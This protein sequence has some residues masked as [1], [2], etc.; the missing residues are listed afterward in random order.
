MI[1]SITFAKSPD[2]IPLANIRSFQLVRYTQQAGVVL[3]GC[4]KDALMY[5]FSLAGQNYVSFISAS[6]LVSVQPVTEYDL[7][8]VYVRTIEPGEV[9]TIRF[10]E[11]S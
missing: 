5:R 6:E 9:I 1:E 3:T 11:S 8:H 10:K 7:K 4:L 2:L